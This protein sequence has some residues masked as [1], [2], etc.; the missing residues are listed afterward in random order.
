MPACQEDIVEALFVQVKRARSHH[1]Q[2]HLINRNVLQ[3]VPAARQIIS[4]VELEL[5]G[6]ALFRRYL[7][8]VSG[9]ACFTP[10]NGLLRAQL[11]AHCLLSIVCVQ[12]S[13]VFL[14]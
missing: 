4:R 9:C 8:V 7:N 6:I 1:Y 3:S 10:S 12:I 14:Q 2:M 5:L 11:H 13:L